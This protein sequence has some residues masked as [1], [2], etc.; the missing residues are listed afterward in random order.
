[1]IVVVGN[2]ILL[3]LLGLSPPHSSKVLAE[4]LWGTMGCESHNPLK[5]IPIPKAIPEK[6]KGTRRG[7][8]KWDISKPCQNQQ[9]LKILG[10]TGELATL[11]PFSFLGSPVMESGLLLT[12]VLLS[13]RL[14]FCRWKSSWSGSPFSPSQTFSSRPSVEQRAP[15]STAFSYQI[16]AGPL[17]LNQMAACITFLGTKN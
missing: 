8:E 4:G 7:W 6:W 16:P 11:T 14:C 17:D 13:Q 2:L 3:V 5:P 9:G 1:M 12:A 10:K 15:V